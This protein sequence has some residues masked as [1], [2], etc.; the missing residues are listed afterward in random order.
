MDLRNFF[1]E[2]PSFKCRIGS[3]EVLLNKS[4][5]SGLATGCSGA[6][7]PHFALQQ[8]VGHEGWTK[9]RF[10]QLVVEFELFSDLARL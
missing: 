7:A 2:K 3:H 1:M 9:M 6:E 4:S 8:L 10:Q 5:R